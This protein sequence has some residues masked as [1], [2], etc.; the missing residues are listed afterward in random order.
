MVDK[1]NF[2]QEDSGRWDRVRVNRLKRSKL[3][4]SVIQ[5]GLCIYKSQES[6]SNQWKTIEH[7]RTFFMCQR[8]EIRNLKRSDDTSG[9][10]KQ[11]PVTRI[12]IVCGRHNDK[13]RRKKRYGPHGA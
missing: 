7:S 1:E 2:C 12:N 9:I 13:D 8:E 6:L 10:S 4:Y 3:K 5:I 11:G